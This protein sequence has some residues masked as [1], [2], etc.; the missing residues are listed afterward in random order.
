MNAEVL[1]SGAQQILFLQPDW[2]S[3]VAVVNLFDTFPDA[4]T[5]EERSTRAKKSDD[6]RGKNL[7]LQ[8]C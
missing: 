6:A 8:K 2:K 3:L 1:D 5:F 4:L 7:C